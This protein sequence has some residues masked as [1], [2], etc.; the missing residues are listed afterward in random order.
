VSW[1]PSALVGTLLAVALV[2]ACSTDAADAPSARATLGSAYGEVNVDVASPQ[3]LALRER[4]GIDD[5]PATGPAVAPHDDG[6]P[7]LSLPCL[8]G[9]RDVD[10]AQ[11]RGEPL[12]VNFWA[13]YCLPC[14]EE[15][16]LLQRLHERA[17]DRVR[18]IGV[19]FTDPEPAAAL[20]LADATGVT[21]PLVA[22]P[23]GRLK[24][25]LRISGL[26]V[27]VLVDPDGR[28]AYTKLGPVT[29]Y[30]ELVGLVREHLGV[31]V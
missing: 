28:V 24:A 9:G 12:V 14:R 16:P 15:L 6:L 10:L 31:S 19:D 18:L 13:T 8:G 29:S 27:T 26:P 2:A 1:A 30:D 22:D 11:L 25:P 5:C 17:G 3:L 21:Y 23:R 20:Q 7:G 4:A